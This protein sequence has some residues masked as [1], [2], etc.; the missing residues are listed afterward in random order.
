MH[1][2][3]KQQ[4]QANVSSAPPRPLSVLL[5]AVM[6]ATAA[7]AD[8][9]LPAALRSRVD[10][11]A[12]L[13]LTRTGVPSASVAIVRRGEIAYVNAY[14]LAQLA[15]RRAA[16]PAMRYAIGSIS[17]QFTAAALLLLQ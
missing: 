11:A 9:A 12:T 13:A 6:L 10:S 8:E 4:G 14:G 15:P 7:R 5:A 2:A 1:A 16:T 17:K 3:R